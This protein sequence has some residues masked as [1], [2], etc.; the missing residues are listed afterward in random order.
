[1]NKNYF[2]LYAL[3]ICRKIYFIFFNKLFSA[4]L[5]LSRKRKQIWRTWILKKRKVSS[6]YTII[7]SPDAST[8]NR[9]EVLL[10]GYY[11]IDLRTVNFIMF[12]MIFVKSCFSFCSPRLGPKQTHHQRQQTSVK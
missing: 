2:K 5:L 8:K 11:L 7:T 3:L 6:H 1:M 10:I 12:Y 4:A 9:T